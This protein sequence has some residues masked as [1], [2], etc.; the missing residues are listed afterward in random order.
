MPGQWLYNLCF[1]IFQWYHYYINI[2]KALKG[3]N[4]KFSNYKKKKIAVLQGQDYFEQRY[5]TAA[6]LTWPVM[7]TH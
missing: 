1:L 7:L 3:T 2:N 5:Y 6:L 4:F